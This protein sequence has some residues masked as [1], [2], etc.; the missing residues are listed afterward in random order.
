M[1]RA[2]GLDLLRFFAV[3]LV[4]GR[5]M[6]QP[7]ETWPSVC[8]SIFL[9]LG[10]GGWV[11]VD[12]FF[13]LSGFLVSGL[14]F[15]EYKSRGD[16]SFIRFYVRR[17]WRIYPP[18]FVMII[19]TVV[20]FFVFSKPIPQWQLLSEIFFLQSYFTGLWGHTW[21]LAVEEHFYFLLPIVL[22]LTLNFRK[23]SSAPFKPILGLFFLVAVIALLLRF[24]NWHF[25]ESYTH[26]THLFPTH[27]RFDSLFCGVAIS[28][29]YH[30][31]EQQFV[32]ILTP[33]RWYLMLCGVLLL[34]PAFAFQL[35]T[36][37]FVFTVGFTFFYLG[38]GMLLVS[39]LLIRFSRGRVI[40]SLALLGTYSYSIYLWHF[41]VATW[42]IALIERTYGASLEFAV[43]AVLYI[44]GSLALGVVMAKVVEVPT[45][46][47]RDRWY[48]SLSRAVRNI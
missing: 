27:L 14:L 39:V 37:T 6:E 40:R 15:S 5:H 32:K 19:F 18:F 13:V 24:L 16:F 12:L 2:I 42:G 47:L 41:V 38:S 9:V 31:H 36:T 7:P 28:Y 8:R 11:G 33:W 23:K 34:S 1:T 20:V 35:E 25:R 3:M 30:F 22:A 10:G 46:R 29:F 44:G 26:P 17:A 45:I 4:L 43:R 21:S 48:P